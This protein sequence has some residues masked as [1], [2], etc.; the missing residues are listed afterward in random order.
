MKQ[1]LYDKFKD[2]S[3]NIFCDQEKKV[4]LEFCFGGNTGLL[5]SNR[6]LE[7]DLLFQF[8]NECEK[9]W[10][11]H[12]KVL[13]SSYPSLNFFRTDQLFDLSSGIAKA[14]KEKTLSPNMLMK[15]CLLSKDISFKQVY[16]V[17]DQLEVKNDEQESS[18]MHLIVKCVISRIHNLMR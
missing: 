9:E 10:N 13:R 7:T 5:T 6:P 1:I 11:E 12:L 8:L 14:L 16:S 18:P 2:M 17:F 3:I 15:L 4:K